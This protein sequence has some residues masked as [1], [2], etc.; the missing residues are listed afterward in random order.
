[1]LLGVRARRGSLELTAYIASTWR[2]ALEL[3][4]YVVQKPNP[5]PT[6][7]I[8]REGDFLWSIQEDRWPIYKD[9]GGIPNDIRTELRLFTDHTVTYLI[10]GA[11]EIQW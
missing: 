3:T 7:Y 5:F 9:A 8:F 2:K 11:A 1:M 10:N 4:K 6:A